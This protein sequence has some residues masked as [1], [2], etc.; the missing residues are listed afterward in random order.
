MKDKLTKQDKVFI[1]NDTKKSIYIIKC[2]DYYKIGM[3]QSPLYR[4]EKLQTSNPIELTMIFN[5]EFK[6]IHVLERQLHEY[7]KDKL[8]YR[9]WFKLSE[10][11]VEVI[12]YFLTNWKGF[13]FYVN[14]K[15]KE[16]S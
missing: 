13:K 8:H 3:S 15:T 11:D 16:N 9:E 5:K 6:Y 12:I 1:K 2:L 14:R 10:F 4:M 7:F